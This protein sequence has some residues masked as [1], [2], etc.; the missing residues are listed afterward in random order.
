DDALIP[1]SMFPAAPGS[2]GCGGRRAVH[3]HHSF[4]TAVEQPRA[5]T[6]DAGSVAVPPDLR[7]LGDGM[8]KLSRQDVLFCSPYSVLGTR[9]LLFLCLVLAGPTLAHAHTSD[10]PETAA[11]D[12]RQTPLKGHT[13]VVWSMAYAPDGRTLATGGNDKTVRLWDVVAKRAR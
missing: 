2:P 4:G 6:W 1:G 13:G 7:Y 5:G 9:G 10:E 3:L 8:A 12:P 11:A